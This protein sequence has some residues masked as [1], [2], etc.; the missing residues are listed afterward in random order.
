MRTKQ[1]TASDDDFFKV[2]S[3]FVNEDIS[4]ENNLLTMEIKREISE[5]KN[6]DSNGMQVLWLLLS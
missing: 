1:L 6:C 4:T 5:V 2:T 3:A